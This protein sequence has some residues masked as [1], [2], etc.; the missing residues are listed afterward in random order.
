LDDFYV[1]VIDWSIKDNLAV[2]L[3]NTLYLWGF[4]T[5]EINKITSFKSKNYVSNVKFD[6]FSENLMVGN[7]LGICELWDTGK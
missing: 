6:R 7:E 1:D 3:K 4:K 2:G 5:N